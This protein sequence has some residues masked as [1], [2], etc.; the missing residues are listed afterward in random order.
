MA[1][2]FGDFGTPKPEGGPPSGSPMPDPAASAASKE[3]TEK[4]KDLTESLKKQNTQTEI[5]VERIIELS[6]QAMNL[7]KKLKTEFEDLK[8]L[9][10]KR[11]QGIKLTDDEIKREKELAAIK[12]N[13]VAELRKIAEALQTYRDSIESS[14]EVQYHAIKNLKQLS[15]AFREN[16]IEVK[17]A[18][19]KLLKSLEP[20][21]EWVDAQ[22]TALQKFS[23]SVTGISKTLPSFKDSLRAGFALGVG[24]L[25]P[26]FS[27]AFSKVKTVGGA[28]TLGLSLGSLFGKKES[29]ED[30]IKIGLETLNT[31]IKQESTATNEWLNLLVDTIKPIQNEIGGLSSIQEWLDLLA[32]GIGSIEKDIKA[33]VSSRPAGGMTAVVETGDMSLVAEFL[34][35]LVDEVKEV[36]KVANSIVGN[37]VKMTDS[38]FEM[39]DALIDAVIAQQESALDVSEK[40]RSGP[41]APAALTAP[42]PTEVAA[43]PAKGGF[44]IGEFLTGA[45]NAAAAL[46]MIAGSIVVLAIGLKLMKDIDPTTITKTGIAMVGLGGGLYFL[47]KLDSASLKSAAKSMLI[48]AASISVLALGMMLMK[49]VGIG[50]MVKTG[51]ALLGMVGVLKVLSS[52]DSGKL[53]K[54]AYSLAIVGGSLIPLALGMKLMASVSVGTMVKSGVALLGL[55]GVLYAVSKIDSGSLI[56][57]AAAIAILGVS[58][59]PLSAGLLLMNMVN[60]ESIGKMAVALIGLSIAAVVLGNLGG[61]I[62]LGA[63]A[64]AALGVAMIPLAIGMLMFSMI[65]WETMG[66]AAVAIIGFSLAAA[67]LGYIA[68]FILLGAAAIAAL[69]LALIPFGLAM[70]MLGGIGIGTILQTAAAIAVFAAIAAGLGF[71]APLVILGSAAIGAL[72]LA[73]I[74]LAMGLTLITPAIEAFVGVIQAAAEAGAGILERFADIGMNGIQIGAGLIAAAAGIGAV[75]LAIAAFTALTAASQVGGAVVG[76]IGSV[77]GWFTGSKSL[78]G[79][80]MLGLFSSFAEIAPKL[81]EGAAAINQLASALQNFSSIQFGKMSGLDV[82]SAFID[83]ISTTEGGIFGKLKSM[84]ES[85]MAF[86]VSQPPPSE[87]VTTRVGRPVEYAG[88]DYM[89]PA[90]NEGDVLPSNLSF[91]NGVL[92]TPNVSTKSLIAEANVQKNILEKYE[93][94]IRGEMAQDLLRQILSELQTRGAIQPI[95]VNNTTVA[96]TTAPPSGGGATMIPLVSSSHGDPTKIAY[97]VSY[98]PAG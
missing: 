66:I 53:L 41:A 7:D 80:E 86:T 78:S 84:G 76:A 18:S 71:V 77:I 37:T 36:R 12:K 87:P 73:L 50:E 27:D 20:I 69:G 55:V 54:S 21:T 8:K 32:S 56:K 47:S 75:G 3:A 97:Q 51:V 35:M 72:G 61:Q 89:L 6:Q 83:K 85:L 24:K 70:N 34:N 93:G 90:A 44:K 81:S 64:I 26:L 52:I 2:T 33:M 5:A 39:K 65:S 79:V 94:D 43:K 15:E 42:A 4:L 38:L 28:G 98:R 95:A 59:I 40:E 62:L 48:V 57:G 91:R 30:P 31:T 17:K 11:K 16:D 22:G 9:E 82:L 60:W 67:G 45:K 23:D 63:L 14:E 19:S 13:E 58:L 46:L 92:M 49:N 10:E 25:V 88:E 68:P 29:K 1:E 74:P 96:Q